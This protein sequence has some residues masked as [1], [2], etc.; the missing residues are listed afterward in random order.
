MGILLGLYNEYV[1]LSNRE[2]GLGRADI[3]LIPR[4]GKKLPGLVFELKHADTPAALE[5]AAEKAL[6]QIEEKRYTKAFPAEVTEV[7]CFGIAFFGKECHIKSVEGG[8]WRVE[9][10][11]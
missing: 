11:K 6:R 9:L 3:L 7:R 8:V 10:N 2:A 1:C 4:G 5:E